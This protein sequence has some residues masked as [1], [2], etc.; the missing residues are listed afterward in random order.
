MRR[1]DR[2]L[3]S[4]FVPVFVVA[5]MFFVLLMQLIDVFGSVWRYIAHEV[6]LVEIGRIAMLYTPKCVAYSLP[7]AFLFAVSFT[8]GQLYARGELAAILGSGVSLYRLVAPFLVLAS[9][10]RV[11]PGPDSVH[12][13]R[14]G[15]V[16]F[17][18]DGTIRH[19]ARGK[20]FD[21]FGG[22]LHLVEGK[23]PR[24]ILE[25]HQPA[26]CAQLPALIVD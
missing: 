15:F 2:M 16:N 23:R 1:L 7:I 6:P 20:P 10:A 26:Q 9:L 24:R 21:D 14:D 22:G 8:L 11:G 12:G 13:N 17:L 19:R 3:L 25:F 18:A 5:T 4:S